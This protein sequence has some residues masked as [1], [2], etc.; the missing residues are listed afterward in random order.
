MCVRILLLYMCILLLRLARLG[1]IIPATLKLLVY[2][3]LGY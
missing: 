3:A 1:R 2:A